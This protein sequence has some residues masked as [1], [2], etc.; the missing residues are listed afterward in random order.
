MRKSKIKETPSHTSSA[1]VG[2]KNAATSATKRH[3]IK[4]R[5]A[6]SMSIRR[7]VQKYIQVPYAS[8]L[9]TLKLNNVLL[10]LRY[11][12]REELVITIATAPNITA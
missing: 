8:T 9:T 4:Y 2:L 10:Y 3:M 7:R 12:L 11:S 1:C 6:Q 5:Y